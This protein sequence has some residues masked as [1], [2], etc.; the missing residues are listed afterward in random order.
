MMGVFFCVCSGDEWV[1]SVGFWEESL[2]LCWG[3]RG[4]GRG[5]ARASTAFAGRRAL[6]NSPI[7]LCYI[8]YIEQRRFHCCMLQA[9]AKSALDLDALGSARALFRLRQPVDLVYASIYVKVLLLLGP[10]PRSG[11]Y[12][13]YIHAVYVVT[14]YM[15]ITCICLLY[16]VICYMSVI[17]YVSVM[18][19]VL[20]PSCYMY[21]SVIC[22]YMLYVCDMLYVC[23]MSSARGGS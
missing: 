4:R 19:L 16:V 22:W 11:G 20:A 3:G 8:L 9:I 12:D 2:F 23:Y 14:C 1:C 7:F 5:S 15:S 10:P 18:C 17:C 13:V 6:S 21:M